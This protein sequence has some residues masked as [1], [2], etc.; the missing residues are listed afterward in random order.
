MSPVT[1]GIGGMGPQEAKETVTNG[2]TTRGTQH[3]HFTQVGSK[4]KTWH[5]WRALWRGR[6]LETI[7]MEKASPPNNRCKGGAMQNS[8]AGAAK[9]WTNLGWQF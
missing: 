4:I 7:T 8:K 3:T 5:H 9:A 2:G 1:A 6:G